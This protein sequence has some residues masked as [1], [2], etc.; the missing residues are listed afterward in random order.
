MRR[1][2]SSIDR[3]IA[4]ALL[5]CLLFGTSA[6]GA[7]G[8]YVWVHER[9]PEPVEN[10]T[11]IGAGDVLEIQVF[12]DEQNSTTGRVLDDGTMTVPLLGPVHVIGLR[13]EELG[14]LLERQLKRFIAEPKVTVVI[15]ESVVNVSVIGEVKNAKSMQLTQPATVLEAL[16]EAGGLTEFASDSCIFVLRKHGEKTERIRFSYDALVQADAAATNF[17]LKTGDV[18]VVD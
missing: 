8:Q 13:S 4:R 9:T 16:A 6:C 7:S 15:R 12:G 14:A 2:I 10:R 3:S 1:T 11:L 18:L 5:I 17:T